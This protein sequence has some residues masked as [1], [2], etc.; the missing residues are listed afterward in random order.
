MLILVGM[1]F[2]PKVVSSH[3]L[4]VHCN[5]LLILLIWYFWS[6]QLDITMVQLLHFGPLYL[7][8]VCYISWLCSHILIFSFVWDKLFQCK[9]LRL[10]FKCRFISWTLKSGIPSSQLFVVVLLEPSI[11]LERSLSILSYFYIWRE[12][13]NWLFYWFSSLLKDMYAYQK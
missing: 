9:H 4:W 13:G 2:S 7:W 5:F 8:C 10:H 1:S 12:V 11:V 6:M 3:F